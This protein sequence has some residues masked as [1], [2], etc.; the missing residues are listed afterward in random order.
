MEVIVEP[1]WAAVVVRAQLGE[2]E[3]VA[4]LVAVVR[5]LPRL[6]EPERFAA[7]LFTIARRSVVNQL[8]D[9]YAGQ[10]QQPPYGEPRPGRPGGRPGGRTAPGR[11]GAR[12]R[13][14]VL[15]LFHLEDLSLEKCAEVLGV[16]V[17]TVKSRLHRARR[18]IREGAEW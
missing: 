6:K 12:G 14:E 10:P 8:R 11:Q 2:R 3:A 17:G 18:L 1:K 13:G 4:E 16:P 5:G 9:K 7:W 15:V